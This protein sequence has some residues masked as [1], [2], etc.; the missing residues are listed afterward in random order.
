MWLLS[1]QR[2]RAD[3]PDGGPGL[4]ARNWTI[5]NHTPTKPLHCRFHGFRPCPWLK[6]I[7]MTAKHGSTQG[8]SKKRVKNIDGKEPGHLQ[9]SLRLCSRFKYQ[10]A[11]AFWKIILLLFYGLLAFLFLFIF[12]SQLLGKMTPFSET[13]KRLCWEGFLPMTWH[14]NIG[15]SKT[16][17][18]CRGWNL[19]LAQLLHFPIL[20]TIEIH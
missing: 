10:L 12:R 6:E 3:L 9:E 8:F 2:A 19:Y 7:V 16:D 15:H 4:F 13:D 1:C 11:K 17:Q 5:D 14:I 20:S 18:S